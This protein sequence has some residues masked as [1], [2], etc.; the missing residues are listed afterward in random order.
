MRLSTL[1]RSAVEHVAAHAHDLEEVF[2]LH[3]H[4]N[5]KIIVDSIMSQ[6]SFSWLAWDEDEPI[7]VFGA[8]PSGTPGVWMTFLLTTPQFGRIALPLTKFIRKGIIPVLFGELNVRR[9]QADLHEKHVHIHR[10]VK[11][12]G[13]EEEGRMKGYSPDGDY[14]RFALCRPAKLDK[15]DKPC[16]A[17]P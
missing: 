1:E 17:T 2:A 9:L 16:Y 11:T 10:W 12:L 6:A 5:L 13:A 3:G 8:F 4:R 15:T 7:A 14:L